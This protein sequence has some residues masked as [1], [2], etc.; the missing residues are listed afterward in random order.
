MESGVF[1]ETI[2]QDLGMKMGISILMIGI[3]GMLLLVVWGLT[4]TDYVRW[5]S[6]GVGVGILAMSIGTFYWLKKS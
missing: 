2:K 1:L 4:L 6:I 3:I 5:V